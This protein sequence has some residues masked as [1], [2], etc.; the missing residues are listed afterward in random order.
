MSVGDNY[1]LSDDDLADAFRNLFDQLHAKIEARAEG[2]LKNR[3][4][5]LAGVAH[6]ALER[7]KKYAVDDGVIQ[8]MSGGEEKPETP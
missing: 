1:M 5:A 7:L 4:E 6:R 8:P 2:P 3:A